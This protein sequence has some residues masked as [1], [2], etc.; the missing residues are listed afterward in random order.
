[1]V[2]LG[3]VVDNGLVSVNSSVYN[4]GKL[5]SAT[6]DAW[7]VADGS[8]A[9]SQPIDAW[10]LFAS[11]STLYCQDLYGHILAIDAKSGNVLW[12]EKYGPSFRDKT[13]SEAGR[14]TIWAAVP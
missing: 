9:W 8:K 13:G 11:H 7:H 6:V 2:L 10:P 3:L 1:M 5:I 12:N 14:A 4:N